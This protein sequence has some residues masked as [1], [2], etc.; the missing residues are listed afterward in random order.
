MAED[1]QWRSMR[2]APRDGARVLVRIRASEQGPAETDLVRWGVPEHSAEECWISAD[3]EAGAGVFYNDGELT[4]WMPAGGPLPAPRVVSA[5]APRRAATK[6]LEVD[7][8]G[9]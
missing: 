7:G 9:I 2:S 3:A 1:R 5:E 8:S 6:K 4:G